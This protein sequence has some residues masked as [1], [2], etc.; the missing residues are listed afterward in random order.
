M[1]WE[2][3]P[4]GQTNLAELVRQFES[5]C[6]FEGKP[7]TTC[8]WYGHILARYLE[9]AGNAR[10]EDYNLESVREY[11]SY[12]RTRPRYEDHATTLLCGEDVDD[13]LRHLRGLQAPP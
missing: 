4:K 12:A 5:N 6:R 9:W 7:E 1:R 10:L 8:R 11:L 3:M 13:R 2:E